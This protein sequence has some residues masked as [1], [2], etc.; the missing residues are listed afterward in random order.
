MMTLS[1]LLAQVQL[2]LTRS[3]DNRVSGN[4]IR[5]ACIAIINFFASQI[6]EIVPS[7][8]GDKTFQTTGADDG[9]FCTYA[10][11]NGKTRL[12]E[13]KV[14][15]NVNHAPPS[16]PNVTENAYW[17]EVSSSQSAAIPEW[18]AGVFGPGLV[19]VYYNHPLD[20]RGLYV[21]TE[22]SRPFS[23]S[24]IESEITAVKWARIGGASLIRKWTWATSTGGNTPPVS[25]KEN[26][27]WITQDD[28]L[29]PVFIPKRSLMI[30]NVDGAS[31][32]A[33]YDSVQLLKIIP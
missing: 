5:D 18:A 8:A 17:K 4:D 22:P 6:A 1:Q 9:R 23:S 15:N 14:D 20:G 7:W 19:I 3:G 33:D 25:Q 27:Q 32:F 2:L 16:A 12:F 31:T 11:T 30:A 26:Q 29:A 10:D 21:L 24:N 13:T 28:L